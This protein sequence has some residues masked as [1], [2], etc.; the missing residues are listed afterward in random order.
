MNHQP[1]RI[2]FEFT[3]EDYLAAESLHA[4]RSLGSRIETVLNYWIVPLIGALSLASALLLV[5]DRSSQDSAL[6]LFVIG[7]LLILYPIFLRIR[8]RRS[9]IRNHSGPEERTMTFESGRIVIEG[10]NSR[11]E[12]NWK[13]IRSYRVGDKVTLI[14]LAPGRFIPIPKR[15]CSDA[16]IQELHSLL[17]RKLMIEGN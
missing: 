6:I 14:Y 2:S 1:M 11:S 9:Y 16:V 7:P 4:T 3:L 15:A 10:P 17:M 5:R 13:A 8:L 12:L